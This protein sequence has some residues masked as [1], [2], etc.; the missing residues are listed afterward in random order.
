MSEI[1]HPVSSS[2][3]PRHAAEPAPKAT[4]APVVFDVALARLLETPPSPPPA[5]KSSREPMR[6]RYGLD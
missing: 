6:A 4:T 2:V 3:E 5:P 1:S